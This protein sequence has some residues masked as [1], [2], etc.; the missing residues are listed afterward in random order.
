MLKV[1]DIQMT[2]SILERAMS[3]REM[4]LPPPLSELESEVMDEVWRQERA[5]VRSVMEVLNNRRAKD[6][7]YTTNA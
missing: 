1:P 2:T 7:A 4:A 5:T 6:R 3:P